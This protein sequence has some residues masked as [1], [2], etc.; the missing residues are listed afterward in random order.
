MGTVPTAR[1]RIGDLGDG[2]SAGTRLLGVSI[3][4]L[5]LVALVAASCGG[6]E[7]PPS[8]EPS[9]SV[10]MTYDFPLEIMAIISEYQI[11]VAMLPALS[12]E[13]LAQISIAETEVRPYTD[14]PS[15]HDH[16]VA[17]AEW[18]A[19]C[20]TSS[21][22]RTIVDPP[23]SAQLSYTGPNTSDFRSSP[24]RRICQVEAVLRFPPRPLPE[25]QAEWRDLYDKAVQIASC[26]SDHGF[27]TGRPPSL[28][29]YVD[30]GG[31]WDPF[32][33][34]PDDID[35]DVWNELIVACRR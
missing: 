31:A 22:F 3:R 25:T 26:L 20:L 13:E 16:A 15:D 6:A 4:T 19:E 1:S 24:A 27:E 7:H 34:L 17:M 29:T 12:S 5:A 35:I 2:E 21:G 9:T 8:T 14:F 18:T 11:P 23:G 28:D 33:L 10:T 32:A 30:S